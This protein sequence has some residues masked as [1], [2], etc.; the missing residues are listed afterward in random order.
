VGR[1]QTLSPEVAD[2]LRTHTAT[3]E[4]VADTAD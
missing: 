2:L 1:R 3:A 4:D